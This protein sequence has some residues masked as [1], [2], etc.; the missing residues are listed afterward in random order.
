[1]VVERQP[2]SGGAP[3]WGTM[4]SGEVMGMLTV[5]VSAKGQI[6]LPKPLRDQFDLRAGTELAVEVQD[7]R[8]V[9]QRIRRGDW[10]QM[11][12]AFQGP[13][14]TQARAEERREELR[15]DAEGP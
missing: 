5:R 9:M 3:A 15:R 10:R 12:G 14:L 13:S 11:R 6:S 2:A 7:Q 1:V 8:I 4:V